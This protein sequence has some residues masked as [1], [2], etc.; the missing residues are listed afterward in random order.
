MFKNRRQ[1]QAE[2][3]LE[4]RKDKQDKTLI[5]PATNGVDMLGGPRFVAA[6]DMDGTKPAQQCRATP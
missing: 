1:M 2:S 3:L 6:Y 5:A 4:R